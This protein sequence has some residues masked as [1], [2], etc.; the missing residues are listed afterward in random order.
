MY[1][2]EIANFLAERNYYIGGDDLIFIT[3]PKEHPQLDH[4]KYN[5]WNNQYEMWD[6]EGNYFCFQA[7]PWVEAEEKG[8][9]KKRTL[10]K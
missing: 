2:W 3:N 1:S 8:L 5:P 6:R 10:K 4:I 7:M 9:V